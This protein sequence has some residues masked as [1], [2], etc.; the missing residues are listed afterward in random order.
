[1]AVRI[2]KNESRLNHAELVFLD[3]TEFWSRPVLPEIP[4]ST[5]DVRHEVQQGERIDAIAKK[6]FKNANLWWV[7]AHVNNLQLLPD[8]LST[9]MLLRIPDPFLVRKYLFV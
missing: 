1:M 8:G 5:R 4:E 2:R 6:Y 7:I 9:G 3:E